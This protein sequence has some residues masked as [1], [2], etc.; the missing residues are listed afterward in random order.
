MFWLLY[1]QLLPASLHLLGLPYS[2]IYNKIKI[3]QNKNLTMVSKSSSERNSRISHTVNQTLEMIKLSEENISK[4]RI[5]WKLGILH[6]T[7]KLQMQIKSTW[8][9]LKV[10]LQ[11]THECA[12]M[13][14]HFSCVQLFVDCSPPGSSVH[15][16]LQAR[17][18]EWVV[19]PS[20]RGIHEW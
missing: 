5:D 8:I 18:L 10:L 3:R 12:S 13:L 17:I 20:S 2:L 16:I 4:S 11:W 15:G 1:D 7:A 6:Q 14:S 19:M 9:K